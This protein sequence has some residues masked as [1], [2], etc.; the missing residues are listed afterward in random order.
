MSKSNEVWRWVLILLM[1]PLIG[2]ERCFAGPARRPPSAA[3]TREALLDATNKFV[4][5]RIMIGQLLEATEESVTI[6]T[7]RCFKEGGDPEM[8]QSLTRDAVTNLTNI[9]N[10]SKGI[11]GTFRT[12]AE[13]LRR[14]LH[15]PALRP[16]QRLQLDRAIALLLGAEQAYALGFVAYAQATLANSTMDCDNALDLRNRAGPHFK[17]G[18]VDLLDAEKILGALTKTPKGGK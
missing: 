14:Y 8:R 4:A 12:R 6:Q 16:Q 18:D 17:D 13:S 9:Q 10:E 7:E 2:T 3:E 11:L 15:V 5:D 1:L